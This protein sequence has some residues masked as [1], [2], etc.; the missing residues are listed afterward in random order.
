M[1]NKPTHTIYHARGYEV[2]G[3]RRTEWT[4]LGVLFATP[5]GAGMAGTL[6]AFP[7][8]GRIIILPAEAKEPTEETPA[9]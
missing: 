7:I 9:E 1:A 4:K 3:K 5:K 6:T 2:D 8:D